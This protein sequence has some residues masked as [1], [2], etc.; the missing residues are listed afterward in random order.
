M[1][2][3]D[4]VTPP[5]LWNHPA[6]RQALIDRDIVTVFRHYRRHTGASQTRLGALTGLAQSDISAIER[7]ARRVTSADVLDR[8]ATGLDVPPHLLS[9]TTVQ[10]RTLPGTTSH[11]VPTGPPSPTRVGLPAQSRHQEDA[12]RRRN[13]I[14]GAVV[15][16]AGMLA[17]TPARAANPIAPL[18]QVVFEP[19]PGRPVPPT[20]LAQA[21]TQGRAAFAAARYSAL[22]AALP[23]LVATAEATRDHQHVG[24]ARDQAHADVARAYVLAT[25]LAV[26]QHSPVAWTTSDRALHA[27]RASGDPHVIAAAARMAAITQ[28]RAG[29]AAEAA[30]FL[31][32]TALTLTNNHDKQPPAA[33]L[34]AAV[35]LLLT[36][37]YSAAVAGQRTSALALLDEADETL[38]RIARTPRPGGDGLLFAHGAT[39]AEAAMYRISSYTALGTPDDGI[40]YARRIKPS[41]LPTPERAARYLT[42]TGRMWARIGDAPRTYAALRAIERTAPEELQRP[43]LR[44]LT[45]DLLHSQHNLAGIRAFAN[46]HGA[47][48]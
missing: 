36:A 29:Q 8:T 18:E 14:T 4:P 31:S 11:S 39:P 17:P 13:L 16:S 2:P 43:A 42:D 44:S 41:T 38:R 15:L 35:I 30:A 19:L 40:P 26:K 10:A 6:V 12:M 9:R 46:R 1:H 25:E 28:R 34:D 45:T 23:H 21:L 32:R 27:A 3:S 33:T 47:Y 22:G 20:D 5:E 7:G 48:L 37:G 24:H